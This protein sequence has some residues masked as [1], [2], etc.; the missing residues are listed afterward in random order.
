MMRQLLWLALALSLLFNVFFAA[1]YLK[2]RAEAATTDPTGPTRVV[3]AL[4]LD[5]AQAA[6][7]SRLQSEMEEDLAGLDGAMAVARQNLLAEL[8]KQSPDL[9]RLRVIVNQTAE[10]HQQRRAA[11][12]QRLNDFL[13][14]LSPEQRQR[15][16][17]QLDRHPQ[18]ERVRRRLRR[19][20]ADGDGRLDADERAEAEQFFELKRQEHQRKRQEM[21]RLFDVDGDGALDAEEAEAL[22][23]HRR[24]E[25][26]KRFD[27]DGDGML[28]EQ[29][30]EAM[31]RWLRER[32]GG[33]PPG[34]RRPPEGPPDHPGAEIAAVT[35]SSAVS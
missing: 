19:F 18:S 21:Q 14:M 11:G 8:D 13:G 17:R 30:L 32:S 3:E 24:R 22:R 2:S 34:E 5:G 29:E 27:A 31:R 10:L 1:G 28:N 7:F 9:D 25:V 4:G 35:A 12:A 26:E 20:D 15:L 23:E 6:E 33:P 16:S